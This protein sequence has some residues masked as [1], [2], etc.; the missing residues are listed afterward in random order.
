MAARDLDLRRA[1]TLR[2]VA[3]A[4]VC[5]LAAAGWALYGSVHE[6]RRGNEAVAETLARQLQ[7]Q[8]FRIESN[9]DAPARFPDWDPVIDRVQTAGQCVRF[10]RPDGSLG[11][12]SCVG[13]APDARLPPWAAELGAW[14][15]GD[16]GGVRRP[17]G[18]RG[19]DWGTLVVTSDPAVA[20]E[21]A[22]RETSGMLAL[23]ALIAL[24]ICILQF[25]AIGRALRPA[26]RI[27]A[28][29]DRLAC[30][31]LSC[32]LPAVGLIE[33]QR[34]CEAF[35]TLAANLG[36]STRERTAL[37][38]RLVDGC[39]QERHHLARDLHDELAQSLGAISVT[40]ASIRATAVRDCP[41]LVPETERLSATA[42][43]L[44][45]SLRAT[46]Q[47]LRPPEIDDFGLAA[48]LAALARMQ[49]NGAGGRLA[50]SLELDDGLAGLPATA[51]SHV[52]RI[53]Q[54]GLTNIVKH[55]QARRARIVL[56]LRPDDP[57][58]R[59]DRCLWL[60]LVIE[61]DGCAAAAAPGNGL[62]LIGMRER[63]MALGGELDVVRLDH[64][65]R[66]RAAIP[67]TAATS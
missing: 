24:A 22:W 50:I 10:L 32:R 1:L 12:S 18:Y 61:N 51:A 17:I 54:E 67:F 57:G 20:L 35:N 27:L 5:F 59:A 15:L 48:S 56:R 39:E 36:Q 43:A 40:A 53:V 44:M 7:V 19:T 8:L 58:E 2:V 60:D 64:G 65:F 4:V 66:L 34:I 42:M 13:V 23:T 62:G 46:L 26:D 30:G 63:A 37:A 28:G 25:V 38:A 49:E 9:I 55:A 11:R 41:A 3:A 6:L 29:L 33:L 47:N 16:S 52:Y 14:L 31:D 45:R 21:A